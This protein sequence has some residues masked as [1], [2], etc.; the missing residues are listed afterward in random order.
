ME[1]GLHLHINLGLLGDFIGGVQKVR[2]RERL[3]FREGVG[4][5]GERH[6]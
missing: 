1:L 2:E 6:S 5:G 4:G 3:K